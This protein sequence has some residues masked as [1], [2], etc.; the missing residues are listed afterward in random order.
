MRPVSDVAMYQLA[1]FPVTSDSSQMEMTPCRPNMVRTRIARVTMNHPIVHRA[2]A[3]FRRA[4]AH[5][6]RVRRKRF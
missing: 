2:S 4:A 3:H 1:A 5:A 6:H